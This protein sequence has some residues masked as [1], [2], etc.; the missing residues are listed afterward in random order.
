MFS[1]WGVVD[2][3][4]EE[5][6][7]PTIAAP[8]VAATRIQSAIRGKVDRKAAADVRFRQEL[9][10]RE[11]AAAAA[12]AAQ[13]RQEDPVRLE[14]AA[15]LI[16]S[17]LFDLL[18]ADG[19][20]TLE[21]LEVRKFLVMSGCPESEADY[22]LGDVLRVADTDGDGCIDKT[23]F[24]LYVLGD[25]DLEPDGSYSDPEEEADICGHLA[26]LRAQQ[27]YVRSSPSR[28]VSVTSGIA[29]P[30]IGGS[31]AEFEIEG[32]GYEGEGA[33]Y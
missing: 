2:E 4:C 9:E 12:P 19:S 31:D 11:A 26:S 16:C 29:A 5:G 33:A 1:G 15:G 30:S 17:E 25:A 24:L 8:A 13:M 23:E 27:K 20:G 3:D 14:G 32:D 18:D 6:V 21:P 22:Y 7:P 10:A 28:R